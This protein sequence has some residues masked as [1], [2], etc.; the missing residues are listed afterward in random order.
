MIRFKTF[1]HILVSEVHLWMVLHKDGV[2]ILISLKE[3][4]GKE[5]SREMNL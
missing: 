3:L 2:G 4:N 5:T 1:K